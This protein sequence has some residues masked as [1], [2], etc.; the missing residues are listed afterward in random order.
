MWDVVPEI[1]NGLSAGERLPF[2]VLVGVFLLM[3]FFMSMASRR[4]KSVDARME[5]NTGKIIH[6]IMEMKILFIKTLY[7]LHLRDDRRGNQV[8]VDHERRRR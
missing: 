7:D 2:L 6:E 3:V 1:F 8:D 4:R 5:E